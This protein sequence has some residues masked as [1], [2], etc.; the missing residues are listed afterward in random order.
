MSQLSIMNEITNE[1]SGEGPG[2]LMAVAVVCVAVLALAALG[3]A[4]VGLLP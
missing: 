2:C 1:G 4:A 3:A